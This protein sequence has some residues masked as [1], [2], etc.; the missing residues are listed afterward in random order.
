MEGLAVT[1][2]LAD[3]EPVVEDIRK[4][5]AVESRLAGP[6][7]V[8]FGGEFV[9]QALEGESTAGVELEDADDRLG[10][11]RVRHDRLVAVVDIHISIGREARGPALPHLL[12]HALDHLGAQVVRVVL[13]HRRHHV[14]R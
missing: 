5:R 3:V 10:L 8:P 4:R 9:G 1:L 7:G 6:V 2:Q 11:L 13:R 12:V 14:E